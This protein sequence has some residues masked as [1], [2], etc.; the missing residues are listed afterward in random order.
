MTREQKARSLKQE[1]FQFLISVDAPNWS[2]HLSTKTMEDGTD[3]AEVN[4]GTQRLNINPTKTVKEM[5]LSLVHEM[6]HIIN[7]NTREATILRWEEEIMKDISALEI[8][9]LLRA[10]FT[11]LKGV[12]DD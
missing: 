8:A 5:V 10:V 3:F 7:P 1:I 12:W 4:L 11:T 9:T 6:L 2:L